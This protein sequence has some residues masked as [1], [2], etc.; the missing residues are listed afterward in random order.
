VQLTGEHQEDPQLAQ[1]N[2]SPHRSGILIDPIDPISN[3]SLISRFQ[4]R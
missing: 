3:L 4:R 2:V 1:F